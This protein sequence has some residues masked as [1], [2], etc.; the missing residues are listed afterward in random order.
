[1]TTSETRRD[2]LDLEH[3][4]MLCE[5]VRGEQ[6]EAREC[7]P[8]RPETFAVVQRSDEEAGLEFITGWQLDGPTAEFIAAAPTVVPALLR[9]IEGLRRDLIESRANE[10]YARDQWD[11]A[12]VEVSQHEDRE[13]RIRELLATVL[14]EREKSTSY[15]PARAIADILDGRG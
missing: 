8:A 9:E 1:M 11:D 13:K 6:W 7:L 12:E 14:P 4:Q 15:A 10:K 3:L 2:A 5:A